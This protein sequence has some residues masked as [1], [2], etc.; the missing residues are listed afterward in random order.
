MFD[1]YK[2]N[3]SIKNTYKILH[4]NE[5][6]VTYSEKQSW[7][8]IKNLV[9]YI[10]FFLKLSSISVNL[11]S[12]SVNFLKLFKMPKQFYLIMIDDK[13]NIRWEVKQI[14]LHAL[15]IDKN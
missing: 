15:K 5:N 3:N 6:Y 11:I 8:N 12:I 9:I 7:T 10:F 1:G 2:I 4:I 13:R 14:T